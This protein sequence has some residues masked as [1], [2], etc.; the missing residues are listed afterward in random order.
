MCTLAFS[1]ILSIKY[2]HIFLPNC[3]CYVSNRIRFQNRNRYQ[4]PQFSN[5]KIKDFQNDF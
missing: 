2:H 4:Q 5:M 3:Y 1:K